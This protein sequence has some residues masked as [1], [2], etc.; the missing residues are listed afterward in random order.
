MTDPTVLE[1]ANVELD[2]KTRDV[3]A[4]GLNW[5]Y[6]TEQP[7]DAALSHH[8]ISTPRIGNRWYWFIQSGYNG[9]PVVVVQVTDPEW[10]RTKLDSLLLNPLGGVAE[11]TAYCDALNALGADVTTWWNGKGD[12]GSIGLAKPAHPSLLAALQRYRDGCQNTADDGQLHNQGS[13]FCRCDWY[14]SRRS[15]LLTPTWPV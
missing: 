8:G 3:L 13:V 4:A 1:P 7:A 12:S 5:L 10:D 9:L 14:R 15:K 11:M 6:N 2:D